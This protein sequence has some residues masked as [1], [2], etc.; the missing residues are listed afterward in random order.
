MA[1]LCRLTVAVVV[2]CTGCCSARHGAWSGSRL[3]WCSARSCPDPVVALQL[4]TVLLILNLAT[5][6]SGSTLGSD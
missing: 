1:V 6:T 4:G 3:R 2:L 5:K